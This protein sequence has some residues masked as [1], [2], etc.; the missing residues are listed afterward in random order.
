MDQ[1]QQ[2]PAA[3]PGEASELPEEMLECPHIKAGIFKIRIP[4]VHYRWQA[5]ET[6]QAFVMFSGA[7]AAIPIIMDAFPWITFEVAWTIL[8]FFTLTFWL[9]GFLGDPTVPGF[10][11]AAIPIVVMYVKTF[12]EGAERVW[13]MA[14]V[15]FIFAILCLI[16]GPTGLA[17]KLNEKVPRCIQAGIV[18]GAGI[19]AFSGELG[20]GGRFFQAP[21]GIF[22]S[23]AL[24][25]YLLWSLSFK[26]LQKKNRFFKSLGKFG[27]LPAA[28]VGAVVAFVFREVGAPVVEWNIFIPHFSETFATASIIGYGLPPIGFII[29]AIP[30]AFVVYVMLF[31]D[32]IIV[33]RLHNEAMEVRKDEKIDFN[34]SRSS[35][36]VAIRNIFSSIMAPFAP[37]AGPFWAGVTISIYERHKSGKKNMPSIF[38]GVMSFQHWWPILCICVPL[39]TLLRPFLI[40]A[41]SPLL[42]MQGFA[43]TFIAMNTSKTT[44]DM[45]VAGTIGIVLWRFGAIYAIAVGIILWLMMV[46]IPGSK[47]E[48]G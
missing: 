36:I 2:A 21:I 48:Q 25:F 8:F 30:T 35:T 37:L 18:F 33:D 13:A 44:V 16:S 6:I 24:S 43:C 26:Q 9:T 17:K 7:L 14:S 4:F 28:L 22:V 32:W 11:T 40:V 31:G 47:K 46:Y 27:Y 41:T 15:Q 20:A 38:G 12:P 42:F 45:G 5:P 29:G 3:P 39:V 23:T 1:E 19:S 34:I 10:M